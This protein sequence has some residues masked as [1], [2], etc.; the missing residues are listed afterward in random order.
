MYNTLII[1][2]LT[3][4]GSGKS[5]PIVRSHFSNKEWPSNICTSNVTIPTVSEGVRCNFFDLS[6]IQF[7]TFSVLCSAFLHVRL[8]KGHKQYALIATAAVDLIGL[9]LVQICRDNTLCMCSFAGSPDLEACFDCIL[10][11]IG[12]FVDSIP[13]YIE[14]LQHQTS[15]RSRRSW[16]T[17][18]LIFL[19]VF[20]ICLF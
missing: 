6:F 14:S 3:N 11:G 7:I 17:P 18:F 19:Y 2:S 13:H 20:N 10:E 1:R 16:P 15:G 4:H 9:S 12:T 5:I 8:C